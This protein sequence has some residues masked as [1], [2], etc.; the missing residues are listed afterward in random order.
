[1]PVGNEKEAVVASL[2][3]FP[4][5]QRSIEVAQVELSGG[6]LYITAVGGK[7]STIISEILA[8]SEGVSRI[9]MS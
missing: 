6:P 5:C 8:S 2:E 3:F 4:V 1:M 9:L 7:R